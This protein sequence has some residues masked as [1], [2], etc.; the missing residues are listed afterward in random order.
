[1]LRHRNQRRPG[2]A[3]ACRAFAPHEEHSVEG[4]FVD[5]TDRRHRTAKRTNQT[6]RLALLGLT[7]VA[8]ACMVGSVSSAAGATPPSRVE[9][10]RL[11]VA[12]TSG[13]VT[14][15][16]GRSGGRVLVLT[17][18]SGARATIQT[19]GSARLNVLVRVAGCRGLPKLTVALNRTVLISTTVR[20][21]GWHLV[22]SPKPARAGTYMVTARL[23][24]QAGGNCRRALRIDRLFFAKPASTPPVTAPATAPWWRPAQ[25]TTWQW[26][27]S[28]SLNQSVVAQMYDIDL[29]DRSAGDVASLHA[30]GRK[31]ICYFSAG[32]YEGGR[33]DSS[34][35]PQSVLGNTLDGW[36]N[37]KWLDIRRLDVL[38]PIMTKRLDLCRAK[39][40]DGVEPD[41][42]DGYSNST[43]FSLKAADQ[44]AYNRF[45]ATQAHARGLSIGLKN[46]LG[47]AAA[48]EPSFD[49]AVNEQCFQY[50]ECNLLSPFLN[51]GKAVFNAEYDVP[52]SSL[53]PKARSLK[54]MAIRKNLSLDAFR[55]AC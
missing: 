9:G 21:P 4:R 47:Q 55:E 46:D 48:L 50:N 37:E 49:F 43:G 45:L 42:I 29:F 1:M 26:Q 25:N 53:C 30:K 6:G 11:S 12:K 40:F 10:E 16:A 7:A 36:P 24:N 54:I 3:F 51:A 35:F 8:G 17:G 41:N 32:S 39:G 19:S 28:G 18:A 15:E 33:P 22:S 52:T 38:G 2:Q 31:V 13:Q 27:L 20:R 34:S 5:T 14:R 44:L 23:A